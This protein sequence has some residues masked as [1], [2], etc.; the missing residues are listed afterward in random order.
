MQRSQTASHT[1]ITY[2]RASAKV[3]F[4]TPQPPVP[5][6]PDFQVR[7]T[8][9]PHGVF[10]SFLH[11]HAE[12]AEHLYCAAG[13]IRL[14]LGTKVTT[15]GPEDGIIEIP[16]WTPHRWEVLDSDKETIVWERNSPAPELKELFFR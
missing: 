13:E 2:D 5:G 11:F 16:P 14:T 15:V 12:H 9:A 7:F 10:D 4:L 8:F 1:T 3:E 6:Y